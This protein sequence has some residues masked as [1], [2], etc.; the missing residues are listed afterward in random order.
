LYPASSENLLGAA[1]SVSDG[2]E[3]ALWT[4]QWQGDHGIWAMRDQQDDFRGLPA[5]LSTLF[6]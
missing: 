1:C 2:E 5:W 4:E 6:F 3:A